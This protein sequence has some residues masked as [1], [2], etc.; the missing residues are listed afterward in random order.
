MVVRGMFQE[1]RIVDFRVATE[2]EFAQ[3]SALHKQR[4][5]AVNSRPRHRAVDRT[6][7][8]QKFLGGVVIVRAERGLD[9][10]LPLRSLA[11]S[12]SSEKFMQNLP[13]ALA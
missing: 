10:S 5:C 4:K 3:E 1:V 6:R 9:N 2:I 11:Q 12:F 13:H 7:H 8:L